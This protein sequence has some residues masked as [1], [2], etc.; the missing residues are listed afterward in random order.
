MVSATVGLAEAEASSAT[1][2][3]ALTATPSRANG[4]WWF[5]LMTKLCSFRQRYGM[6][7]SDS[8]RFMNETPTPL[9][10][11]DLI[12]AIAR[13][14]SATRAA[15]ALGTTA[16]TVLRRLESFEATIGARL[17]DRLPS[18]L[19]PT[20]ALALVKPWAE[21]AEMAAVGMLRELSGLERRPE[22]TV[23]IAVV[24]ATAALFVVPALPKLR[25]AFPDITVELAPATA[26]VDL[27]LREAD[28]AIR[29]VRPE[30][31]ELVVQ[32]LASV[33]L[34]VM[35]APSL[36]I[37]KGAKLGDLPWLAYDRTLDHIPESRW[38]AARVPDARVVMRSTELGTLLAAAKVGLGVVLMA[39]AVA[40]RAGGSYRYRSRCPRLPRE[41]CGSSPTPRCGRSLESRRC[42]T[43]SSIR[44][45]QDGG[46]DSGRLDEVRALDYAA[47]ALRGST[48]ALVGYATGTRLEAIL[49]LRFV[50]PRLRRVEGARG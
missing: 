35:R 4:G 32:Q 13:A 5:G 16:A 34:R 22:G 44:F 14:G 11:V 38:L 49:V 1:V 45:N 6:V 30:K 39:D 25:A 12:L 47:L 26:L 36:A 2:T 17:F 37:K 18:G 29:T 27:S 41:R 20:P 48:T 28:I 50:G 33:R 10:H 46:S 42:G 23:R 19:R 40:E 9:A 15:E 7:A 8:V 31:G 43:G 21:Q 3:A 24:P